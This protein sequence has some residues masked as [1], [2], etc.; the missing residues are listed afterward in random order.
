M[1]LKDA[2]EIEKMQIDL[3]E[4][5]KAAS[6]DIK[7]IVHERMGSFEQRVDARLEEFRIELAKLPLPDPEHPMITAAKENA[8]RKARAH[9]KVDD[10]F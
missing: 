3:T 8:E 1:A 5:M 6:V 10:Y 9:Q 2:E 7:K 4:R